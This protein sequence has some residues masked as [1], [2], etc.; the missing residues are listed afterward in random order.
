MSKGKCSGVEARS[1]KCAA[2]A[3]AAS[4]CIGESEGTPPPRTIRLLPPPSSGCIKKEFWKRSCSPGDCRIFTKAIRHNEKSDG[5]RVAFTLMKKPTK[6]NVPQTMASLPIRSQGPIP[7]LV[8][9]GTFVLISRVLPEK[10]VWYWMGRRNPG[11]VAACQRRLTWANLFDLRRR[12]NESSTRFAFAHVPAR[13]RMAFARGIFRMVRGDFGELAFREVLRA[14]QCPLVGLDFNDNTRL[15]GT[16]LKILDRCLC[17]FKRELPADI[18][19]LLPRNASSAQRLS[20][21]RNARKL[22]PVSLGLCASRQ[23]NLPQPGNEKKHDVF[24]SGD[25]GSDV[26]RGEIR[27]LEQLKAVGIRV[28]RPEARLTQQEFLKCCSESYLVWSPEG[29]GWDCFRHYE[30][31]AAGS[32]PVMNT[33]FITPYQPLLHNQHALYYL[34]EFGIKSPPAPEFRTVTEGFVPTVV[35]ALEDRPRLERMGMAAREFA[36]SH[37]THEAIVHHIISAIES[38]C[39]V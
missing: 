12:L 6:A 19:R 27:L 36:L 14:K 24:F 11:P 7:S 31:A 16:A 13:P 20:L 5:N 32:V 1:W 22:M 37:H 18:Q 34:S 3:R 4:R 28:F 30:S 15:S 29:A 38:R 23:I 17:Y 8:E 25:L 39:P 2:S 33:P 9:I 35:R 26:R 21:E 10:C